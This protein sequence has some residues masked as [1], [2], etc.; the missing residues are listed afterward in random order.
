MTNPVARVYMPERKLCFVRHV[1]DVF[2]GKK[3]F[4][5]IHQIKF[6]DIPI[7]PEYTILTIYNMIKVNP[8]FMQYVPFFDEEEYEP[9]TAFDSKWLFSLINTIDDRFFPRL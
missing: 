2:T 1:M 7:R 6:I 3:K 8:S 5:Y 9:E 4:F